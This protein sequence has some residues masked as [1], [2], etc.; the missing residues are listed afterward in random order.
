MTQ[1]LFNR[2]AGITRRRLLQQAA[3][4]AAAVAVSPLIYSRKSRAED[5]LNVLAWCDHV[6]PRLIQPFEQQHNVHVNLKVYDGTGVALGILEQAKPGDWDV[7][8]IDSTDV[9]EV[10]K[11]GIFAELPEKEFDWDSIFKDARAP[12]LHYQNGKLLAVPEKYGYIAIAY[13][14]KRVDP[15]D[16]RH[17]SVMWNE[18]YAKRIGIHDYYQPVM[19]LIGIGLGIKPN[20]WKMEDLSRLRETLVKIKKVAGLI[21]DITTDQTALVQGNVDLIGGGSEF[22]VSGLM[23]DHPTLDWVVPDEGGIRWMQGLAVLASSN[24]KALGIEFLKHILSPEGQANL[25][26]ADCY[27][28]MPVSEK[29]ALSDEQKK[30]LRWDEQPKFLANSYFAVRQEPKLD[31]AMSELWTEFLNM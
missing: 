16:M 30:I 8:V 28:A 18:K 25:A 17:T 7:L 2:R 24:R 14:S 22:V 19:Q 12:E 5:Q 3:A 13:D 9:P 21:G 4:G 15:A 1:V 11:K 31:S 6:D 10:A 27:W 26:T 29:A 20:E 23:K